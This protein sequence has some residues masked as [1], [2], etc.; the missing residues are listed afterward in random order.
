MELERRG[1]VPFLIV[2]FAV[3]A[4]LA[5]L[6]VPP[7]RRI[8]VRLDA[9]DRPEQRRVNTIPVPRGGGVAVAASFVVVD[10]GPI[11]GRTG[12]SPSSSQSSGGVVPGGGSASLSA[13]AARCG[14]GQ[15]ASSAPANQSSGSGPRSGSRAM[16]RP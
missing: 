16:T 5:Y 11:A 14:G 12:A 13:I 9:V 15:S 4:L 10:H 7:I 1:V 8:A 6:L 2:V 3:A